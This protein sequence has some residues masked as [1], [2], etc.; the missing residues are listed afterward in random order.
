M[1]AGSYGVFSL[2]FEKPWQRAVAASGLTLGIGTLKEIADA[3]NG[4]IFSYHDFAYN[5]FGTI[6][7][8]GISLGI[9]YAIRF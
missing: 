3:T 8:L 9:D 5:I 6:L 1:S 7:G 4:G 2:P